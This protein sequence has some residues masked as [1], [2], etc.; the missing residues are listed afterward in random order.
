MELKDVA[1]ILSRVSVLLC[2]IPNLEE[3]GSP[4]AAPG[5]PAKTPEKIFFFQF[6][7]EMKKF[8]S[9]SPRL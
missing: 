8:P 1:D 4:R 6:S 3:N 7:I 9:P 2:D 5:W